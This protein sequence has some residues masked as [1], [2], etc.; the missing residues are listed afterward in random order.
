MEHRT[1]AEWVLHARSYADVHL[2]VRKASLRDRRS[3]VT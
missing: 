3:T 2:P 1:I